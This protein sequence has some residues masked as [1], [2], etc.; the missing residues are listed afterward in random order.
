MGNRLAVDRASRQRFTDG[1]AEYLASVEKSFGVRIV[2]V[3]IDAPRR[4]SSG[5]RRAAEVAMDQ[6][7][8][9]CI[10][11]PT[12][13]EFSE[14]PRR[15]ADHLAAGGSEACLPRANQL[16]MLIGFDL[17][18]RLERSY[19]CIE[20]FPNAIVQAVAPSVGHKSTAQGFDRQLSAIAAAA[21]WDPAELS[22]SAYGSRHD[23]LDAFMSAWIAS[24]PLADRLAHGDEAFDTIWSVRTSSTRQEPTHAHTGG[25]PSHTF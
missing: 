1:V 10:A 19:P 3:A 17:F 18:G 6:A 11:T 22:A 9:S 16:W 2:E 15:I 13:T 24:L 12:A 8:I 5:G 14:M 7:G 25:Q 23:K 21:S 20:V 4:P